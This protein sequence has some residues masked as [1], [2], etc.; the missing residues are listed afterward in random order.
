MSDVTVH[1]LVECNLTGGETRTFGR[2]ERRTINL[3]VVLQARIESE[4]GSFRIPMPVLDDYEAFDANRHS[5]LPD[6]QPQALNPFQNEPVPY[7]IV[8]EVAV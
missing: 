4:I 1:F 8:K 2:S 3:R 6:K 7:W 5:A